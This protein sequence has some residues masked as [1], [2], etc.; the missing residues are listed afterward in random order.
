MSHLFTTRH[1]V[2][3]SDF[4]PAEL[5]MLVYLEEK[6]VHPKSKDRIKFTQAVSPWRG[7]EV[8]QRESTIRKQTYR[9]GS[10]R[11][12]LQR[13]EASGRLLWIHAECWTVYWIVYSPVD[14]EVKLE[15]SLKT[16]KNE[17]F[18]VIPLWQMN[19]L[20]NLPHFLKATA[21][22]LFL[23]CSSLL[24]FGNE[25]VLTSLSTKIFKEEVF[26]GGKRGRWLKWFLLLP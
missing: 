18:F 10:G 17:L 22:L 26:I 15:V 16:L 12:S 20:W 25:N 8:C 21:F 6:N 19:T 7:A 5:C 1:E 2:A 3:T 4:Q 11:K 14:K 13:R 24:H 9:A 23:L